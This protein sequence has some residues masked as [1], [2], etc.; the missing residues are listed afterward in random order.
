LFDSTLA[1]LLNIDADH[2]DYYPDLAAIEAACARYVARIKPGGTLVYNADDAHAT[3]VAARAPLHVARLACSCTSPASF[4]AQVVALQPWS[5]EFSVSEAGATYPVTVGVPGQHNVSNA[6]Q[7]L[8]AARSSG[9]SVAAVQRACA[10]F[11][12]VERRFQMLGTCQGA[13]IV[14][15]YAHHPREIEATLRA[16]RALGQPLLVVFQPHRF[17]RTQKLLDEFV[18]VLGGLDRLILTDIFGASE[19]PGTVTGGTLYDRVRA[20]APHTQ[21]VADIAAVPDAVQRACRPGDLV[22]FLGAG[23]ISAAAHQL[24]ASPAAVH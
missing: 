22:L 24:I 13:T 12:G 1:V 2:L 18:C 10:A 6:L 4:R 17:S 20:V 19:T 11:H 21:Y 23:T 7:A 5:S 8:A 3:A 16:A 15:D 14:D 9:A